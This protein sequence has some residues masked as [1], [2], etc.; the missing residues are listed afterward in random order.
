MSR[1]TAKSESLAQSLTSQLTSSQLYSGRQNFQDTVSIVRTSNS[2]KWSL[3][4]FHIFDIPS[5]GSKPF[6]ERIKILE[7]M[8]RDKEKGG[9]VK[10]V[11]Q[12][13]MESR[14]H[15]LDMLKE[16]E[17]HG[18]EGLMLRKPGS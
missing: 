9:Q 3:I 6:E 14:D 5:H 10:I 15:V 18:G 12:T 17:S 11:E 8:F 16:V 13:M 1:W 7:D 2:P 4:S